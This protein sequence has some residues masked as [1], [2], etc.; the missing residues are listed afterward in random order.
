[1][2][3]KFQQ[4]F[5]ETYEGGDFSHIKSLGDCEGCGDTLVHFALIE[6][7]TDEGCDDRMS[8]ALRLQTA[9]QQLLAAA[10]HI[11]NDAENSDA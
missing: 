10:A 11:L 4:Q 1:M 9:A 6:L 3:N 5:L 7:S 8:A 2:L